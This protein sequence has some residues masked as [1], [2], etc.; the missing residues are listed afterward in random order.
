M[1]W[2]AGGRMRKGEEEE[3]EQAPTEKSAKSSQSAHWPKVPRRMAPV[4]RF[5]AC[6]LFLP[7]SSISTPS[8]LLALSYNRALSPRRFALAQSRSLKFELL[9]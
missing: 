8:V 7:R 1:K 3:E 5:R 4:E 9:I 6:Q 2:Q